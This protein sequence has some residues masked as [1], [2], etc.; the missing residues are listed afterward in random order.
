MFLDSRL[1]T[2]HILPEV[3]GLPLD[4]PCAQAWGLPSELPLDLLAFLGV[5][6]PVGACLAWHPH[7]DRKQRRAGLECTQL[8]NCVKT[9]TT[10]SFLSCET[11]NIDP[12]RIKIKQFA[13]MFNRSTSSAN[14]ISSI[15]HRSLLRN[16]LAIVT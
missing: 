11:R 3:V 1:R 9:L 14:R 5:A 13:N 12:G 15:H 10:V 6:S 8:L 2:G 4:H 7:T 16:C